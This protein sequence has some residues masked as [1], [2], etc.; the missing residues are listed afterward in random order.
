LLETLLAVFLSAM[1]VL[2]IGAAINF[3]LRFVTVRRTKVEEAQLARALLQR[4]AEDLR[5]AVYVAPEESS[6]FDALAGDAGSVSG[7]DT[8]SS[9]AGDTGTGTGSGDSLGTSS[10]DSTTA[11]TPSGTV[12]AA[13]GLYG[14]QYELQVDV[15]RFPRPEQYDVLLASGT[16]PLQANVGGHLRTIAYYLR[17]G[18]SARANGSRQSSSPSG[19]G[20]AAGF[21]VRRVLNRA[22]SVFSTQLGDAAALDQGEQLLAE[23]VLAIEFMYFD[24]L[25][26]YPDWDCSLRGGLPLAVS[27][28]VIVLPPDGTEPADLPQQLATFSGDNVFRLTVQL[29]TAQPTFEDPT[30]AIGTASSTGG[31]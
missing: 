31:I 24:G 9:A 7:T 10:R 1:L 19:S 12:Q 16:D 17:G 30:A 6:S 5:G 11:V 21:L 4:I 22:Q 18:E 15:A 14:N 23:G 28:T 20:T 25:D 13:P 8:G 29:P 26:W 3:Y 2:L 27:V